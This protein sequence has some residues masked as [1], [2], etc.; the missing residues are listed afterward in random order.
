MLKV[1][2]WRI[3]NVV[4]MKVLEQ[5]DE[6]N[7]GTGCFYQDKLT[8]MNIYSREMP[9]LYPT[10]IY[11]K[12]TNNDYNN[13]LASINLNSVSDAEKFYNQAIQTI[14]HYNKNLKKSRKM[15]IMEDIE[16]CEIED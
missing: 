1:K 14:K 3:E 6:I 9:A 4:L 16:M 5:G 11:V 8:K 12:G 10:S 7:K 13:L 2:F 15:P